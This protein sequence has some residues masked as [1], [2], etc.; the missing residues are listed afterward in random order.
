M[1]GGAMAGWAMRAL[2]FSL[3]LACAPA[4]ALEV[5]APAPAIEQPPIPDMPPIKLA[6]LKG[7]VVLVDF[8]ASWCSPCLKSLP[9]Y[10][11]LRKEFDRSDFEILAVSV[12]EEIEDAR[13]FLATHPVSYP[14]VHDGGGVTALAYGLKAMPSSYLID[15]AGVV[16]ARHAGFKE[17]DI[18]ALRT[19]IQS[20]VKAT[21]AP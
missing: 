3:A 6:D 1:T 19:E 2:V 18:D 4:Q 5:G 20:L 17:A 14:V 16:H 21:D 12:D 11:A 7:K 8:W 9:L 10:D 13:S 15:R